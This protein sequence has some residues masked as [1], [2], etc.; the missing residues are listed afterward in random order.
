[1][2]FTDEGSVI[3]AVE[4]VELHPNDD[5][6]AEDGLTV[7]HLLFRV[8]D[9]GIGM[10]ENTMFSL[11]QR[12]YQG[13]RTMKRMVRPRGFFLS[14]AV[15]SLVTG[16]PG[17]QRHASFTS[18]DTMRVQVGGAGLG[19][20]ISAELV[21]IMGGTIGVWS[22]GVNR[23]SEFWFTLPVQYRRPKGDPKR[24]NPQDLGVL[25]TSVDSYVRAASS[26]PLSSERCRCG[27]LSFCLY[28]LLS[29]SGVVVRLHSPRPQPATSQAT[30]KNVARVAYER[31]SEYVL[32]KLTP[33]F[34]QDLKATADSVLGRETALLICPASGVLGVCSQYLKRWGLRH[35]TGDDFDAAEQALVDAGSNVD[36]VSMIIMYI[37]E[38]DS[39]IPEELLA[40]DNIRFVF[41]CSESH[42]RQR[43]GGKPLWYH[44]CSNYTLLHKP[45]KRR[46]LWKALISS[47]QVQESPTLKAV[48]RTMQ[49]FSF[50]RRERPVFMNS[51]DAKASTKSRKSGNIKVMAL[52]PP[53]TP[54]MPSFNFKKKPAVDEPT[55]QEADVETKLTILMAEDNLVNIK[56]RHRFP[57]LP[58][59]PLAGGPSPSQLFFPCGCLCSCCLCISTST[60]FAWPAVH[61]CVKHPCSPSRV[62]MPPSA[63]FVRALCR[64]DCPTV[65]RVG[66]LPG[67]RC[68]GW[69]TVHRQGEGEPAL[70]LDPHGLPDAER[71]WVPGH[72]GHPRL[73]KAAGDGVRD[74]AARDAN[75]RNDGLHHARG[76]GKVPG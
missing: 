50:R 59:C 5:Y 46:P 28:W 75:C 21:S 25:E 12:F 3:L 18:F 48:E 17:R 58:P 42:G 55:A 71:R 7:P 10:D 38:E 22:S 29:D 16:F 37:D 45:V 74:T 40:R 23:G 49:D 62:G 63:C 4:L 6:A 39:G 32:S 34:A 35:Y 8:I 20:A 60:W 19:L 33:D 26:H 11:F 27:V 61:S 76:S 51:P 53:P 68:H 52:P 41:I 24:N 73:G 2:K 57:P 15:W 66:G 64:T 72:K 43:G 9:T 67:R 47:G 1:M 54:A 13:N 44:Q 65:H 30:V 70:R 14:L 56:V 69:P 36:N 31:S